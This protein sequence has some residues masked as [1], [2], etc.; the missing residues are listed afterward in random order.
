MQRSAAVRRSRLKPRLRGSW[1]ALGNAIAEEYGILRGSI[2]V[3]RRVSV[4]P[5]VCPF[6]T[7]RSH[8]AAGRGIKRNQKVH[9]KTS[10]RVK[11][12]NCYPNVSKVFKF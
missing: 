7:Y 2:C 5:S 3:G 6:T 10:A 9:Q 8:Q 1:S 4:C 12:K 11:Q